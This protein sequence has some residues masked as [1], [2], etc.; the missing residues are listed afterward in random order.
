MARGCW[1]PTSRCAAGVN[2]PTM[3]KC[4]NLHQPQSIMGHLINHLVGFLG[5]MFL[6]M[7]VCVEVILQSSVVI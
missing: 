3:S 4:I 2:N 6:F 7:L 1:H 5:K